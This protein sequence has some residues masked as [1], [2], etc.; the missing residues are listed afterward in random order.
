MMRV[1]FGFAGKSWKFRGG[2]GAEA[3]GLFLFAP[4]L[5]GA[6]SPVG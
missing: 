1:K 3:E 6:L 2:M 4:I 5:A